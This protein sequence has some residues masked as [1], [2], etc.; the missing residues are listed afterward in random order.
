[1]Q[2]RM[3]QKRCMEY[4]FLI[5]KETKASLKT[6]A[7]LRF[8]SVIF[9]GS[10]L[11]HPLSSEFLLNIHGPLQLP[12]L[13]SQLLWDHYKER[14]NIVSCWLRPLLLSES[15]HPGDF[16]GCFPEVAGERHLPDLQEELQSFPFPNST[17]HKSPKNVIFHEEHSSF[18]QTPAL[19]LLHNASLNQQ[20][21]DIIGS[22]YIAEVCSATA[23]QINIFTTAVSCGAYKIK[24]HSSPMKKHGRAC[25]LAGDFYYNGIW[26]QASFF[27]A[28]LLL[29]F[30]KKKEK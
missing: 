8:C 17:Q 22:Q 12:A 4:S 9:K 16:P 25:T 27:T 14:R 3:C 30:F 20:V 1:M 5:K 24:M 21:L 19:P 13:C 28:D 29:F 2:C 18:L 26:N 11:K 15:Q 7:N 23:V 10:F 6:V